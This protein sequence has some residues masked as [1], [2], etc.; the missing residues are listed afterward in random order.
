MLSAFYGLRFVTRFKIAQTDLMN[1]KRPV[2]QQELAETLT[3]FDVTMANAWTKA[4]FAT[5]LITVAMEVTSQ[6]VTTHLVILEP[7]LK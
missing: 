7:V 5:T 6:T 3:A 4:S 2:K 1:L